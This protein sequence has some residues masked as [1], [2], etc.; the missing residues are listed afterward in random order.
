M[1]NQEQIKSN[2]LS[3]NLDAL[4]KYEIFESIRA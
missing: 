1:T 3:N 4:L 2:I